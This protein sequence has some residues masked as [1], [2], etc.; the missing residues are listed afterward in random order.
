MHVSQ[1]YGLPHDYLTGVKQTILLLLALSIAC[2][3]QGPIDP[4]NDP[5]LLGSLES[6]ISNFPKNMQSRPIPYQNPF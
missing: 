2:V 6:R 5:A 4:G 3:K 1:E